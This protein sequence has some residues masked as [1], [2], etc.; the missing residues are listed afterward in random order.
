MCVS[1]DPRIRENTRGGAG[2]QHKVSHS[3]TIFKKSLELCRFVWFY[4]FDSTQ[5]QISPSL[6]WVR[7]FQNASFFHVFEM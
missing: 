4:A 2:Q 6:K 1:G 7:I 5:T 3:K